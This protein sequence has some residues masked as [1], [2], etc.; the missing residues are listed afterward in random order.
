MTALV[1]HKSIA[2]IVAAIHLKLGAK[3]LLRKFFRKY[4][5]HALTFRAIRL[6]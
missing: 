5:L 4:R 2:Q 6:K 3:I 1:L